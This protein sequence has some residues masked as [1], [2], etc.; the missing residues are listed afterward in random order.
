MPT[1]FKPPPRIRDDLA[2]KRK[3]VRFPTCRA[4]G[5]EKA[6]DGHHVLLR[7]QGGYDVEDNI[8]GLS[9]ACHR[10]YHEARIH[11]RVNLDE[12]LYVLTKLGQVAGMDYLERRR[13]EL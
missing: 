3:L 1:D 12:K 5:L 10:D 6:V 8:I 11:V 7:S 4:C 9:R 2:A 13:Y